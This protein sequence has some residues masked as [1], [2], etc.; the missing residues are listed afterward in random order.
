MLILIRKTQ[1]NIWV[2]ICDVMMDFLNNS[3]ILTLLSKVQILLKFVTFSSI[4]PLSEAFILKIP[5][6]R[7][8]I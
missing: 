4:V 2:E 8:L 6:D 1:T 3:C 5:S 7:M